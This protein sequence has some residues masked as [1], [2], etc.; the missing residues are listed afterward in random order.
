MATSD[1][2]VRA[3]R[4]C[5]VGQQLSGIE[6]RGTI[7][8]GDHAAM[9]GEPHRGGYDGARPDEH[10]RSPGPGGRHQVAGR[11]HLV[12]VDQQ[13][14]HGVGR[15][16]ESLDGEPPLHH[17]DRPVGFHPDP[18]GWI[19]EVPIQR[20]ARVLR[21]GHAD[22]GAWGAHV[23]VLRRAR[24]AASLAYGEAVR[25]GTAPGHSTVTR[26]YGW[27]HRAC[28]RRASGSAGIRVGNPS[29]QEDLENGND[30]HI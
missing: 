20:Q 19:V 8:H 10:R 18:T 24:H 4:S 17:E 7:G 2:P 23:G 1:G 25:A 21:V 6:G 5:G 16:E 22:E 26:R 27:T 29:R 11:C 15:S 14:T 28:R 13:G 9:E 12:V 3:R 30:H